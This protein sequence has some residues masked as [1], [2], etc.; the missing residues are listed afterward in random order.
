GVELVL[1][2][3]LNHIVRRRDDVAQFTDPSQVVSNSSKGADI[4]HIWITPSR[5]VRYLIEYRYVMQ[6]RAV[7]PR[8]RAL[9]LPARGNSAIVHAHTSPA[10][11]RGIA[12]PSLARRAGMVALVQVWT[13][14]AYKFRTRER[15]WSTE[16][17]FICWT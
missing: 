9:K 6:R 3:R 1:Q 17:L 16:L 13:C 15:A 12:H 2:R 14:I 10:R 8:I 5:E 11:Q 4:C 7:V